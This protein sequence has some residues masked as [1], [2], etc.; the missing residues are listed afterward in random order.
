MATKSFN[1]SAFSEAIKEALKIMKVMILYIKQDYLKLK[2]L[3]FQKH[4][5]NIYLFITKY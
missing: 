1:A 5:M 3:V 4:A 2:N